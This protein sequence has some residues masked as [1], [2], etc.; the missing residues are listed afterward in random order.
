MKFE[1]VPKNLKYLNDMTDS[2]AKGSS[3]NI[4]D[5]GIEEQTT[6]FIPSTL[7]TQAN[8]RNSTMGNTELGD[9]LSLDKHEIK[10]SSMHENHSPVTSQNMISPNKL[11]L[12][13]NSSNLSEGVNDKKNDYSLVITKLNNKIDIDQDNNASKDTHSPLSNQLNNNGYSTFSVDLTQDSDSGSSTQLS[14]SPQKPSNDVFLSTQIQ[15]KLDVAEANDSLRSKLSSFK[16]ED[17]NSQSNSTIRTSNS[18]IKRANSRCKPNSSKKFNKRPDTQVTSS[19]EDF[20]KIRSNYLLKKLSGKPNKYKNILKVQEASEKDLVKNNQKNKLPL[21]DTYKETEWENTLNMLRQHF[22]STAPSEI[23]KIH[24]YLYGECK[25]SDTNNTGLWSLSQKPPI[26]H[27]NTEEN[28]M[29]IL[30]ASTEG[31]IEKKGQ[32][33]VLSLS[34]AMND[35]S[36]TIDQS[37]EDDTDV[38]SIEQHIEIINDKSEY[39]LSSSDVENT[40]R[41][42]NGLDDISQDEEKD[43]GGNKISTTNENNII[44]HTNS[45][46][47]ELPILEP[48]NNS[49]VINLAKDSSILDQ[50][51]KPL[52][53]ETTIEENSLIISDS[54]EDSSAIVIGT[55]S[56]TPEHVDGKTRPAVIGASAGA[57][58]YF[59][60]ASRLSS[61]IIDLTTGS[62]DVVTGLLSP[63][64]DMIKPENGQDAIVST[65]VPQK[66]KG[67][68][69]FIP[70]SLGKIPRLDKLAPAKET[71]SIIEIPATRT[72]STITNNEE[73]EIVMI[74]RNERFQDIAVTAKENIRI[75]LPENQTC[76]NAHLKQLNSIYIEKTG[77]IITDSEIEEGGPHTVIET[78]SKL[79]PRTSNLVTSPDKRFLSQS[80]SKI[81]SSM[82]PTQSAEKL[83]QSMRTI[84]L[85]PARAKSEMMEALK[86]AAELWPHESVPTDEQQKDEIH[87]MLTRL[88][89]ESPNLLEKVYCFEPIMMDTVIDELAE[90]NPFI[91][92]I[93]EA[94]IRE[95]ADIQGICLRKS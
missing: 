5:I 11:S 74:S 17:T 64:K 38:S 7:S 36:F 49:N 83:R 67:P 65:T 88:I 23:N 87:N 28:D 82:T 2:S 79:S 77:S 86:A 31:Q 56:S 33:I 89:Q 15:S 92:F 18:N 61:D 85:K 44:R 8:N 90:K 37:D 70:P 71:S 43:E 47:Q 6:R 52:N 35:H 29:M 59:T 76:T 69:T 22:P 27:Q 72:A 21:H 93:D 3:P 39:L 68:E 55:I 16:Y 14:N 75:C 73:Q 81:I 95:W 26:S 40:K 94:S 24:K 62:Y 25:D 53:L 42:S 10:A 78:E 32:N 63:V 60:A 58:E 4:P 54:E 51:E 91:D 48:K 13:Q 41:A 50:S 1:N 45:D 20:D 46:K 9:I 12:T 19:T 30:S 84:G 80:P 66:R 34:Q 57:N